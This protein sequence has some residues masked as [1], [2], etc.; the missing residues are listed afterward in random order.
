MIDPRAVID[1]GAELAEDVS[2]GPFSIIGS[3]VK[4]G[5]GTVIGP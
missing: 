4:I 3:D 5:A 1:K 2:V